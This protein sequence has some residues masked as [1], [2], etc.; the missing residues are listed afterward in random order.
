MKTA[1]KKTKGEM[2][3]DPAELARQLRAFRSAAK[4]LS[5][6]HPRLIDKYPQQWVAV[7]SGEVKAHA[8]TI[9]GV[10]KELAE[11]G[12]PKERA[13]VRFID[14]NQRTLIL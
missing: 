9:E 8:P 3:F 11:K 2:T 14:R 4:T 10:L 7:Y 5:S 6:N 12:I 13:I 1:A